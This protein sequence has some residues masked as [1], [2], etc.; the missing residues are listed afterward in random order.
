M[1][2]CTF[3]ANAQQSFKHTS[4]AGNISGNS[5]FISLPGLDKNPQAIIII[6]NEADTRKT[7]P[8]PTGV[9][10][11]GNRWAIFNQDMTPM[12]A[13]TTFS[14]V[15]SNPASHAFYQ[16]VSAATAG[17]GYLV[18]DHPSLNKQPASSFKLTQVWNPSGKGGVYNN[19]EVDVRYEE[20]S[21]NWVVRNRNGAPLPNGAAF[22]VIITS[23]AVAQNK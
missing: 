6:E 11:D 14:I 12:P 22:N 18:I 8:H 9:W 19:A 16:Q 3:C 10:F 4:T 7:N 20:K 23:T 15:W 13:G 2:L 1:L 5:T 17:Q 21:G